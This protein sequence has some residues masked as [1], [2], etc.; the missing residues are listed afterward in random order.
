MIITDQLD[1]ASTAV[2]VASHYICGD[3]SIFT[4]LL[5]WHQGG[6]FDEVLLE[7]GAVVRG[8][9]GE[10]GEDEGL[11]EHV[12]VAVLADVIQQLPPRLVHQWLVL[13]DLR[14]AALQRTRG[15]QSNKAGMIKNKV[16]I[17][18]Q[19]SLSVVKHTVYKELFVPILFL[20]F[21]PALSLK[22]I[23]SPTK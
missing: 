10:V 1:P 13:H 17:I 2:C 8:E 15:C 6:G 18:K 11:D 4:C 14:E 5:Q 3:P 22:N 20:S 16:S 12:G 19:Q 21:L 7:E 23:D 9:D